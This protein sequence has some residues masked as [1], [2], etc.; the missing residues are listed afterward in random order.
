M[1]F[2]SAAGDVEEGDPDAVLEEALGVDVPRAV[3]A[4]RTSAIVRARAMEEGF[5]TR[6]ESIVRQ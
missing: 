2:F 6:R 3:Q 4:A 5:R 1:P